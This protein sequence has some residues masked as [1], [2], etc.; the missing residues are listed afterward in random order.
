MNGWEVLGD[1]HSHCYSAVYRVAGA[2]P[3]QSD[4]DSLDENYWQGI[5]SITRFKDGHAHSYYRF[6][7][8][9]PKVELI[10]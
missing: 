4:W 6:W 9:L 1:L 2:Y 10:G 8:S 5:L 7:P 3:S